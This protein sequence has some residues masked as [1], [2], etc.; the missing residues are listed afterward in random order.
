MGLAIAFPRSILAQER[1]VC[2]HER[3]FGPMGEDLDLKLAM[4]NLGDWTLRR[5]ERSA[6]PLA[7]RSA[8]WTEP[9]YVWASVTPVV[10]D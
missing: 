9:S 5:E 7:L 3:L 6:P 8:T 10:M 1:A 4:G 2:L